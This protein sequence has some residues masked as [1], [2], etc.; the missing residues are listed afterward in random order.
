MSEPH[1]SGRSFT[2][3][4][5]GIEYAETDEQL[6]LRKRT[7]RSLD[8]AII[9]ML[10][11]GGLL[12]FILIGISIAKGTL[13]A[14]SWWGEGLFYL[15]SFACIWFYLTRAFNRRTVT[16]TR[17]RITSKDG[18]VFS[19]AGKLDVPV[20]RIED[21]IARG[22][23]HM[24]AD[25]VTYRWHHI[26]LRMKNGERLTVFRKLLDEKAAKFFKAKIEAIIARAK[27]G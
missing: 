16:I 23:K 10:I 8:W 12:V 3:G 27:S 6:I 4:P 25:L 7:Y 2:S 9:M 18:P 5:D 17:E 15:A 24:T 1:T 11:P 20:S 21:V 26:E 13:F 22:T 19:L 14:Y